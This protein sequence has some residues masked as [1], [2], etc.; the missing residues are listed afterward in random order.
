MFKCA[1]NYLKLFPAR[2]KEF[3]LF[4]KRNTDLQLFWS[5]VNFIYWIKD[6]WPFFNGA[7]KK[8][9]I[10]NRIGFFRLFVLPEVNFMLCADIPCLIFIIQFGIDEFKDFFKDIHSG[11]SQN[12]FLKT[13]NNK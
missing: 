8:L 1:V 9:I 12:H 11:L 3:Y 2:A 10:N 7:F 5:K 13:S 6:I 4:Q